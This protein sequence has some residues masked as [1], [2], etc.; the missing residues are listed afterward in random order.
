[1]TEDQKAAYVI[2]QA[3]AACIEAVGMLAEN[4][5]YSND[6]PYSHHHFKALIEDYG[7][8]HNALM[9]YFTEAP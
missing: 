1:M 5:Q 6:Q 2:A 8:H 3:A 9:R 4:M 7:L